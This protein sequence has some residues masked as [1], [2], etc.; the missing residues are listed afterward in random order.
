M[1]WLV[2]V[3]VVT[4]PG[5]VSQKLGQPVPLSNL[6]WASNSS[7]PQPAHSNSPGRFSWFR[8]LEPGRS[9]PRSRRT[10][11]CSGVNC[12]SDLMSVLVSVMAFPFAPPQYA[13]T[14]KWLR[15]AAASRICRNHHRQHGAEPAGIAEGKAGVIDNII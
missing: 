10:R 7:A 1:P 6:V 2:S 12:R 8:G 4:A 11:C 9:V 3:V 15:F 13:A 14:G 5:L